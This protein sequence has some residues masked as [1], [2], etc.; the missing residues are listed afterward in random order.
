MDEE[1]ARRI[2]QTPLVDLAGS[3]RKSAANERPKRRTKARTRRRQVATQRPSVPGSRPSRFPISAR[4]RQYDDGI[5]P[6]RVRMRKRHGGPYNV[7]P[8]EPLSSLLDKQSDMTLLRVTRGQGKTRVP[9]LGSGICSFQGIVPTNAP[10]FC[11]A[12]Y[13]F[14]SR[15][16]YEMKLSKLMN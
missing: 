16:Q 6:G 4:R 15:Q 9:L 10:T 12:F 1:K 11:G 2:K 14:L 8:K 7:R 13:L 5:T 3:G